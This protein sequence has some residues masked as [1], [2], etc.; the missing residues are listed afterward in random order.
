M[1]VIGCRF[2][3]FL[4]VG[5]MH[6]LG[7]RNDFVHF[8]EKHRYQPFRVFLIVNSACK[9]PARQSSQKPFVAFYLVFESE[10]LSFE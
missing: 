4:D 2:D 10:A 6:N 3:E 5:A 9:P 1:R 8:E 7:S